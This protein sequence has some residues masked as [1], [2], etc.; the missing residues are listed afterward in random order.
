MNND[1]RDNE[2]DD[3]CVKKTLWRDGNVLIMWREILCNGI[4][5]SGCR[6]NEE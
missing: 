2:G 5:C 6:G 3:I 1:G 4:V